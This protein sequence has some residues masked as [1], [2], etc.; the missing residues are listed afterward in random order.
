MNLLMEEMANKVI[1]I[2]GGNRGIGSGCAEAFCRYGAT[3]VVSARDVERGRKLA[4]DLNSQTP[5]RCSFVRCDVSVPEQV[6]ELV[7]STVREYGRI[8]CMVNNAGYLPRR[9]TIDEIPIEDFE[10]VLK[11]NLLGVF[12]GCKYALPHLRKSRGSIINMGS[13]LG[14]AG[15]EGSSM[16]CATK[17]A[18]AALTKS[19]AIDE[20]KY[21]VRVNAVLP[22]NIRSELG[23]EHRDPNADSV[24]AGEISRHIQWIRRQGEPL[25]IGWTC[26]F[27]ASEMAGYITGAEINVTGGF[28]LGN[29]LRMTIEELKAYQAQR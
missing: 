12:S 16:Y 29:G 27:L 7:D 24:Q 26:V 9:R 20:A 21:G 25:D 3:V 17:A 22:G 6:A 1:V 18:I 13:I 19:L 4:A 14:V 5:G 11:T 10:A 2:T 15:Q 8:D 23:L 28:E